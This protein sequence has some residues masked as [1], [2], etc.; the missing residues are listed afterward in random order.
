MYSDPGADTFGGPSST[1]TAEPHFPKSLYLIKPLFGAYELNAV[2]LTAQASVP[3][4][5][6]LDLDAW[7][8]PPQEES[9]FSQDAATEEAPEGKKVKKGKKKDTGKTKRKGK[10]K[11]REDESGDEDGGAAPTTPLTE[12]AEE[13]AERERVSIGLLSAPIASFCLVL[14]RWQRRCSLS[15]KGRA[16]GAPAGR[17]L[18]PDRRPRSPGRVGRPGRGVDTGGQVR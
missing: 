17:P 7:I 16:A 1:P 15:E 6:G 10:G 11:A 2:A 13:R 4:P 3:V 14:T 5:E 12:T 18:L 9:V 8:V